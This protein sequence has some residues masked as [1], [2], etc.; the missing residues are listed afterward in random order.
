MILVIAEKPDLGKAIAAAIP[1]QSQYD[2]SSQVI[3][4]SFHGE[5]MVICWC[6]GH[7]LTLKDPEDYDEKYKKWNMDD[8]PIFFSN[9]GHK[10]IES[11]KFNNKARVAQIGKLLKEARVVVN[12]GDIDEEGQLLIDELLDWHHYDKTKAMRLNTNDT[13]PAAMA[14]ALEKMESN[15]PHVADGVSAFGRQLCDKVFGYNLTRYYTLLNG[16]KRTLPVGRVKMPTLGLVVNRDAAIEGHQKSFYYT[17]DVDVLLDGK[18]VPARFTPS[19]DDG[20]LVDGKY[21]EKTPLEH[22]AQK[23]NNAPLSNIS[24]TKSKSKQSP[25]LPFNQ[26]KLFVACES[27]YGMKPALTA[28]ITQSL[29]DKHQAITYNRSDCQYLGTETFHE[30][31]TTLPLVC[32][33]LGIDAEQFDTGIQSDCFNDANLTAHTAIIPTQSEQDLSTFSD[34]ER[35]VYELIARYYLIQF[36]PPCIRGIT[37]L[38]APSVNGG[39]IEASHSRILDPGYLFFLKGIDAESEEDEDK[40][41]SDERDASILHSIPVGTYSGKTLRPEVK[42]RENKP[43]QRYT[44]STLIEDMTR[45]SKYCDN[46]AVKKLL[47]EKD[48]GKKG[49]NGSIGTPATRSQVIADL[50]ALGYLREEKKGKK[51]YLIS[52]QLGRE[53]YSIL[54]DSVRK[55]DVSAKWW[56]EQ[57]KIKAGELTPED[58]A[59]DVM[60]TVNAI[61]QS[62]AGRMKNAEVY[63][64]GA[65][66]DNVLGKCPKCG[67]NVVEGGKSFRCTG[68]GCKFQ[69]YKDNKFF[70]AIGKRLTDKTVSA[71]L[72]NR[73]VHLQGCKSKK[74]TKYNA[75]ILCDF[76]GEYPSFKMA[77]K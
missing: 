52:T 56:W 7:F 46:L 71:M 77:F 49:E 14:K 22:I 74:G 47:L 54:P 44:Q 1:G 66:S 67:G 15:A 19:K 6:A 4:K 5:E 34:D 39:K 65:V 27:L 60:K 62:G 72:K 33:N 70:T 31:P 25:P 51:T 43:P 3:R 20:D 16:G 76:S 13:S 45:I 17:L 26:T 57:E 24:I 75:T 55:V 63:S 11:T 41:T 29:R 69:L 23:L 61:L 68:A 73:Q 12:A 59:K 42:Q 48:K 40:E 38:S 36:L 37:R 21:L 64:A 30:A 8:L 32:R 18:T 58:M 2:K 35:K 50:V 28:S 10:V 9:W 53:F